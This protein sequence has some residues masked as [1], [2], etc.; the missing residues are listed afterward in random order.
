MRI[1]YFLTVLVIGLL[2]APAK[3]EMMDMKFNEEMADW[4]LY[5]RNLK[6]D[7]EFYYDTKNM[8]Y[9]SEGS[10]IV[11]VKTVYKS[12][13]AINEL[14]RMRKKNPLISADLKYDSLAYSIETLEVYCIKKEIAASEIMYDIDLDREGSIINYVPNVP[15]PVPI[16]PDSNRED[17]YKI[18]CSQR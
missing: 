17:L 9:P 4:K 1:Y 12:K 5:S 10:V 2:I 3:A 18:V 13:N 7:L 8:M 16:L 15:K 6:H 11:T 14:K